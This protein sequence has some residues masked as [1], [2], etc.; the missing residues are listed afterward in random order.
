MLSFW[1]YFNNTLG[2][3]SWGIEGCLTLEFR[4][5]PWNDLFERR[6]ATEMKSTFNCYSCCL[7]FTAKIDVS[8]L[9][10]NSVSNAPAI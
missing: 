7:C 1:F 10:K 6:N 3:E 5:V 8:L 4:I 2:G 9:A